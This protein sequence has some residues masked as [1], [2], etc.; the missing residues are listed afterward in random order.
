MKN[1]NQQNGIGL[2]LPG[3]GAKGAYQ[4]G[5]A[6]YLAEWLKHSN[7]TITAIAGASVGALNGSVLASAPTFLEGAQRLVKLWRAVGQLPPAEL[8]IFSAMPGLDLGILFSL[9]LAAGESTKIDRLLREIGEA[10]RQLP[11]KS[12]SS[13]V[14]DVFSAIFDFRPKATAN[15]TLRQYLEQATSVTA[16]RHGIPLYV[17]AYPSQGA[18]QDIARWVISNLTSID[19]QH[20]QLLH[21]QSLPEDQQHDAILSSAAIPFIFDAKQVLGQ[22]YVDGGMGGWRQQQGQVP[23]R[24]LYDREHVNT[25]FVLHSSD[26]SLWDRRGTLLPTTIEV[27]PAQALNTGNMVH[28][29][30]HA[31]SETIEH[32]LERGYLDAQRSIARVSNVMESVNKAAHAKTI[33]SD[34]MRYLDRD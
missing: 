3:G 25:L 4:A 24:E 29:F 6:L 31:D 30:V 21:I 13:W 26:G 5:S 11:D 14:I 1:P 8:Q 12:N 28:D 16:L 2:I 27:R 17:S 10:F 9:I 34:A 7:Q 32:R 15:P 23:A 20:S 19:T 22:H 33:L 18:P